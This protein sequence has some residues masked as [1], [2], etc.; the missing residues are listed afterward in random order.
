[1]LSQFG[2]ILLFIV[3]AF[4]MLAGILGMARL[5]RPDKPNDQKL[6][7]YESGENAEGGSLVS[8]NIRFYVIALIFVLFEVE[9][10]FLFPW[11]VVFGDKQLIEQTNGLWGWFSMAEMFVFIFILSLGLVYAWAQGHLDW[12]RPDQKVNP[13]KSEIPSDLYENINKKYS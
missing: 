3:G 4:L 12:L 10:V 8:F 9:L 5:L 6:L 11:S 7:S 1:M 2:F 13:F